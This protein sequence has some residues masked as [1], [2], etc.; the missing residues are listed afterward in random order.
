MLVTLKGACI[1]CQ[2]LKTVYK[3]YTTLGTYTSKEMRLWSTT[4]C[5]DEVSNA[6]SSNVLMGMA[7]A[8]AVKE[9]VMNSRKACGILDNHHNV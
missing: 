3:V 6:F 2:G 4:P 7:A 9:L 5:I 1:R 8:S